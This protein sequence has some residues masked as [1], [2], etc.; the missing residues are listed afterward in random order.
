M[1][2]LAALVLAIALTAAGPLPG[3]GAPPGKAATKPPPRREPDTNSVVHGVVRDSIGHPLDSIEVYSITSGRSARTDENG[4]YLLTNL[5]E[6]PTRLRARRVGWRPSD[7][8][9]VLAPRSDVALNF[10]LG[11]HVAA[12]D[13][14]RVTASQGVCAPRAFGGFA[15]RRKAGVGVFRDSTEIAA[16]NP[17][18]LADMLDGIPGLRREGHDVKA[19]THWRCLEVLVDGHPIMAVERRWL[20]TPWWVENTVAIEFYEDANTAPEWYK[21]HAARCS[22]IVYWL[23]GAK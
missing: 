10:R 6:G 13:T 19:V 12:L 23:R 7:T 17:E 14:I 8:T 3:Q 5:I 21:I 2:R 4:R 1:K 22:L 20:H 18:Y 11:S 16:L 15:C 9:L